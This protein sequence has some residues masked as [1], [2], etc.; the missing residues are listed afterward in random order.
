MS[1]EVGPKGSQG[2]PG[3]KDGFLFTKHSQKTLVPACPPGS[4]RVYFGYSLLFINGNNRGHGQDLGM[5][6]RQTIHTTTHAHTD[7]CNANRHGWYCGNTFTYTTVMSADFHSL[8]ALV[9]L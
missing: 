7:A 2:P 3:T 4:K 5:K 9:C 8:C 1:G 6:H